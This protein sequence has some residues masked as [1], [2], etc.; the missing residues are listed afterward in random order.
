MQRKIFKQGLK[1]RPALL[2][3][4]PAMLDLKLNFIKFKFFEEFFVS[5]KL[6]SK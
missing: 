3:H 5:R 1:S 4:H 2:P 6:E